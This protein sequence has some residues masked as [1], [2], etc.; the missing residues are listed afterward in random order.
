MSPCSLIHEED[1]SNKKRIKQKFMSLFQRV[2][3]LQLE[4]EELKNYN[5]SI[6]INEP[7]QD[8]ENRVGFLAQK[9]E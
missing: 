1:S 8:V 6:V 2:D 3:A 9:A 7:L 5:R 4:I